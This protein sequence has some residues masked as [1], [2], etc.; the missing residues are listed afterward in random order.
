MTADGKVAAK[1]PL[2]Q[3]HMFSKTPASAVAAAAPAPDVDPLVDPP[4]IKD[5][6][7]DFDT[8]LRVAKRCL[9][10]DAVN[11]KKRTYWEVSARLLSI[12]GDNDPV[13]DGRMA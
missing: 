6:I 5:Y 3:K 13:S 12:G 10:A 2:A 9:L 1:K 4:P 8:E 11:K 7:F